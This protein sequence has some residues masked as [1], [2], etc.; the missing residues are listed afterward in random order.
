MNKVEITACK[1]F[2]ISRIDRRIYGSFVEHMGRVVYSGIYEPESKYADKEGFRKDVIDKVKELALTTVRYPGGNFVSNYCWEDG[3]G[4]KETRPRRLDLA[5]KATETNEF[6]TDEF[7]KWSKKADVDPIFTVN[8]GTRGIKEAS[9]YLEYC[10]Y[11]GGTELSDKRI[12]NGAAKPYNIKTWCLGNEMDG[13]WQIGHKTAQEYGRLA[14]EAGKTMKMIDPD[15][16]L[17]V[18]GSSLSSMDSYPFWDQ[19]VLRYTYDV[20][21]YIAIH[22]YYGGQEKGTASFLAQTY[23]MEE[24]IKTIK[25]AVQL[26]KNEKKE[27]KE[28][29]LSL[30]EWGIWTVPPNT[31][32]K[33]IESQ[34]WEVAPKISE[35]IYTHR[36]ALLFAE[37]LMTV[38][39]NADT[40]K[41]ACQALLTNIS[42]CIM[43]EKGGDLWTQTTYYP[44]FY[45]S[46]YAR[47]I[48]LSSV[49][50]GSKYSVGNF[51]NVDVI[52]QVIIFNDEKNELI[53]F[54]VNRSDEVVETKF[55]L[56]GFDIKSI[57]ECVTMASD[58]IT[59]TNEKDHDAVKPQ[60]VD[61]AKMV[62]KGCVAQFEPY[63]FNMIRIAI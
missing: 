21:D 36:D 40:V 37:M 22:Q 44:L 29:Y 43:T 15:I 11:A 16:K 52:D 19:D 1:N 23:D 39:K 10:N 58:D 60:K 54:A 27:D 8:L 25:S 42:S 45:L 5:W 32:D 24:Y 9:E 3:V 14:S 28:L 46:N 6:G 18:S 49:Y 41:I 53:I 2:S 4:P 56:Y 35:Q 13:S 34:K 20:A 57:I 33:E 62:D 17:V 26:V 38:I 48:V 50:S 31:V 47:G 30:D 12:K 61:M 7:V 51:K 63:S 55:N 59:V